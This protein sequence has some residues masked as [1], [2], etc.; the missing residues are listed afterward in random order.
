L[1]ACRCLPTIDG[2]FERDHPILSDVEPGRAGV[3]ARAGSVA[4]V[5]VF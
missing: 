5:L 4:E 1:C 3:V 2:R